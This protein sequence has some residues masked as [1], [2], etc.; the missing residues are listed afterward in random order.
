MSPETRLDVPGNQEA[1]LFGPD[2]AA[3]FVHYFGHSCGFLYDAQTSPG[4]TPGRKL[5]ICT[6]D[7]R[8]PQTP[9]K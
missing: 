2:R 3:P 5:H 7:L 6:Q 8:Q 1:W 9:K 4:L